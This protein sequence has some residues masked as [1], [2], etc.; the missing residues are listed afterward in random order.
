MLGFK[1]I[2]VIEEINWPEGGGGILATHLILKMLSQVRELNVTLVSGT[3]RPATIEGIRC[4]F[5]PLLSTRNK[6][7]LWV[8]L[9]ILCHQDWFLRLVASSDLV[10]V[11]RY[12]FPVI[13]L[14]S[15]LGKRTIVH[16]HDYQ[17][18]S[19][20][21]TILD[22]GANREIPRATR[23]E[24]LNNRG[25]SR[26][27]A[28]GC[29]ASLNRLG[30]T[31]VSHADTVICVSKTQAG[32]ISEHAPELRK[33]ITVI[34]NPLP[35]IPALE[36]TPTSPRSVLY[37]GGD[38]Y[39]KGFYTFLQ[40]S[41]AILRRDSRI[42]FYVAGQ[43]GNFATEIIRRLNQTSNNS[44]NAL[45]WIT[46]DK[47]LEFNRVSQSILF[48]SVSEE[49]FGYAVVESMLSGTIPISSRIGALPEILKGTYAESTMFQPGNAE[50]L[51][52]EIQRVNSLS[53]EEIIEIGAGL[54]SAVQEKFD[55]EHIR[56]QIV[57]VFQ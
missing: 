35:D 51:A 25:A 21:A 27:F 44:Y 19:Y 50:Q 17:L 20:S 34:Y 48:P 52:G 5:A 3:R 57:E 8:N 31:W 15:R 4:I 2:L 32:V 14:A 46:H 40:A 16:L 28:S 33:K 37:L 45:G 30:R 11:S 39:V 18:I 38:S 13:Q 6:V 42:R 9:W 22:S 12:C 43:L 49:S 56:R 55:R 29:F 23:F 7:R 26:A 1:N 54:R 24:I 47:V 41:Q 53:D 10:Y 36:K